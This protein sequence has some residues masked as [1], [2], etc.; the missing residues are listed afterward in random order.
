VGIDSQPAVTESAST[1]DPYQPIYEALGNFTLP[2]NGIEIAD[3]GL[4]STLLV[5][6]CSVAGPELRAALPIVMNAIATA[7]DS[8]ETNIEAVGARMLNCGNNSTLLII[9]VAREDAVAYANGQLT[10]ED[11][12]AL[13]RSQ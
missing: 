2:R 4:G 5:N 7:S 3:T 10:N 9:G 6:I 12:Q 8:L 11:F 1:G 13:W